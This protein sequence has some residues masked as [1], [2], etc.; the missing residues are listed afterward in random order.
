MWTLL[1]WYWQ[2]SYISLL[3]KCFLCLS[4]WRGC[5]PSERGWW[6]AFGFGIKSLLLYV[7][8]GRMSPGAMPP[9]SSRGFSGFCLFWWLCAQKGSPKESRTCRKNKNIKKPLW[10]MQ[11]VSCEPLMLR[12][13]ENPWASSDI[14]SRPHHH[15]IG[16]CINRKAINQKNTL[17]R[18]TKLILT[19]YFS[20]DDMF[21]WFLS[22]FCEKHRTSLRES[23]D[24]LAWKYG[25]L[26]Q[27]SPMFLISRPAD[28]TASG[29]SPLKKFF[30]NIL[31]SYTRGRRCPV[32][33]GD[34]GCR[35]GCRIGCRMRIKGEG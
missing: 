20:C 1:S 26:W 10:L 30:E 19:L 3:T 11:N 4:P 34:F 14:F 28:G 33:A 23:S 31:H 27:R 7:Q 13:V 2:G 29:A 25:S 9:F 5:E 15:P 8:S 12:P 35:I 16:F 6:E 24:V 32:F 22:F 17:P 18:Y 21:V